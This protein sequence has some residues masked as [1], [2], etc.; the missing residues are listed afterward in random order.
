VSGLIHLA[1]DAPTAQSGE[2]L[3]SM[4][5]LR[6]ISADPFLCNILRV[7]RPTPTLAFSR[8]ESL[9][10]G[11]DEAA[12]MALAR[13]FEPIIR[14]AGGR[15]VAL[16][17]GWFV[18]DI[19][20]AEKAGRLDNTEVFLCHGRAF[21]GQLRAW[22]VDAELGPV[23]GEYC[24]GDHSINA[25]RAVK[26]VGTAQ[27]VVSRARLFSAS[28]P[29]AISDDVSD[30]LAEANG[31]LGLEWNPET[32]GSLNTEVPGIS[33]ESIEA[34]LI[35]TFANPSQQHPSDKKKMT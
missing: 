35:K 28:I 17:E 11:Y 24:P 15:A 23:E 31:L 6:A 12:R 29:V 10:P 13:G 14:P 5:L 2:V 20:T 19:I 1:S 26:I 34:G 8:R 27:R 30:V 33:Y 7:Y 32:L 18:V 3:A 9:L 25:R 16:D 21:V 4:P 22:G